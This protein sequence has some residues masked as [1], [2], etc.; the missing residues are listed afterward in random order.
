MSDEMQQYIDKRKCFHC[1]AEINF[2][3]VK[4][5]SNF[6]DSECDVTCSQCKYRY[7]FT[8]LYGGVIVCKTYP[9]DKLGAAD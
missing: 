1:G 7:V 6:I 2:D 8:K 9:S 4:L 5:K 3:F